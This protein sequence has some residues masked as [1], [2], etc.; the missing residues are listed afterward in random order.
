MIRALIV[1]FGVICFSFTV[2]QYAVLL[3]YAVFSGRLLRD[4]RAGRRPVALAKVATDRAMPGVS[5]IMPAYN[6]ENVITHTTVS[7]LAQEYPHI[8]VI[9]VNDGSKDATLQVL[10]DHFDM[11]AYDTDPPPGPIPTEP[12]RAIYRSRREPRIVVVD[13]A[14]SGSKADGSNAG[15]NAASYP[16]V[17]VMDSDEFMERDTIAR[18]MVEVIAAPDT[19][20]MVGGTL[21]PANDIV[22]EGPEIIERHT[23]RNYWVGCQLIEYLTAFLVARPGLARLR[24]MPIVS[25]GFGLFRREAL[26]AVGGYRHG[27]LGEDMDMCLRVQRHLA[28]RGEECRVVQVPESLC[29]T[30]FPSDKGVLRRQRIRWHRGL[31]IVIDDHGSMFGRKR[32]GPVG[33]VG[34]GSLYV[35]EWLGPILEAIGWGMLFGLAVSGWLD[36]GAAFAVFLT[37]QLIGMALTMLSVAIMTKYL[38]IFTRPSDLVRMF[39]WAVALNWGYRQL[40]LVWRIRSLFPGSTGWGEMPRAGFKTTAAATPGAA[41]AGT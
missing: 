24:A 29:W 32:Y 18:C 8:E 31:K 13:K 7:A 37:T 36:P 39:A 11:E 38:R 1:G 17:V 21:L 19:T 41:G 4:N 2:L 20:A 40:T 26:I 33:T 12:V 6:E 14:P 15:I 9:V 22:I 3:V 28:D 35:F 25:G 10:V 34:M 30:E 16:W 23:P 5:V 27:H